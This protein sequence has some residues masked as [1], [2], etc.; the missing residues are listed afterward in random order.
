VKRKIS[1]LAII[2][3]FSSTPVMAADFWALEES[4]VGRSNNL[5]WLDLG[6]NFLNHKDPDIGGLGVSTSE[7]GWIPALQVGGSVLGDVG[8][9]LS[10]SASIAGG[11]SNYNGFDALFNPDTGY[12]ENTIVNV[13]LQAGWNVSPFESVMLTP[14]IEGAYQFWN[15]ETQGNLKYTHFAALAGLK[16][17]FA[18][19]TSTVLTTYGAYGNILSAEMKSNALDTTPDEKQIFR[20]GAKLAYSA[21][22]TPR[23]EF[24]LASDYTSYE[25]GSSA[26]YP[27]DS[28]THQLVTRVG[29]GYRFR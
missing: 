13:N 23:Y 25:Y 11:S 2:L 14:Y 15:R 16:L 19:T 12:T 22:S 6:V 17:Q 29:L 7:H 24:F 5:F 18:P 3:A 1:A 21:P 20:V 10:G 26:T 8:Y 28:W 4:T 9:Y 27:T